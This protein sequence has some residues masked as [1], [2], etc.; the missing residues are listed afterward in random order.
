MAEDYDEF[1]DKTKLTQDVI[2]KF[3]SM[4]DK[5]VPEK[6]IKARL[7]LDEID[8][9][10]T[11]PEHMKGNEEDWEDDLSLH[12]IQTILPKMGT[13]AQATQTTG[14]VALSE[15]LDIF[16]KRLGR[17]KR[18]STET[19]LVGGGN[20]GVNTLKE[21]N[22]DPKMI[23][24]EK[25]H[26]YT[27][28]NK[29]YDIKAAKNQLNFL[30]KT[31]ALPKPILDNM[32][33]LLNFLK[34]KYASYKEGEEETRLRFEFIDMPTDSI[35]SNKKLLDINQRKATYE[36]WGEVYDKFE[37]NPKLIGLVK[38]FSVDNSK[39]PTKQTQKIPSALNIALGGLMQAIL[40]KNKT[41]AEFKESIKKVKSEKA[42][43]L[44]DLFNFLE[45]VEK[46][47]SLNYIVKVGHKDVKIKDVEE[48]AMLFIE[49]FLS[50]HDRLSSI[51][52]VDDVEMVYDKVTT[53]EGQK[54]F[55]E[56]EVKDKETF[57]EQDNVLVED[58]EQATLDP[59][60]IKY[61]KDDL[62]ELAEF[63]SDFNNSML[64][65]LRE[66]FE[67]Y[68]VYMADREDYEDMKEKL[69]EALESIEVV[70]EEKF[71]LPIFLFNTPALKTYFPE[72][73]GIANK[74]QEDILK[75]LD[76]YSNLLEDE[77]TFSAQNIQDIY[78][79]GTGKR[80]L[81]AYEKYKKYSPS[82]QGT[83]RK[84]RGK[85]KKAI[86]AINDYIVEL[87]VKPMHSIHRFGMKLPFEKG[88]QL[89]VIAS[90]VDDAGE[91]YL[92]YKEISK[93][94]N[95]FDTAF[96]D[97]DAVDATMDFIRI[98]TG[99][100]IYNKPEKTYG[101]SE[102]FV[103]K[104]MKVFNKNQK[105]KEQL[106]KEVASLYGSL[107]YVSNKTETL[108]DFMGE[109]VKEAFVKNRVDDPE[110]IQVLQV[111]TNAL[112]EKK[113]TVIE[114]SGGSIKETT[115]D[116]LMSELDRVAK[117]EIYSKLL[118]A[119]DSL[120]ILKGKEIHYAK[121]NENNFDHVEDMLIKMQ[122]EHN[123]DMSAGEL[124]SIVNEIDSFDNI[125]KAHGINSEHVYLIKANFR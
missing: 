26:L 78:V 111:L 108:A 25:L 65:E 113:Q 79:A 44:E 95:K 112:R 116:T 19:K 72:E 107:L 11:T 83:V 27:K 33:E 67:E 92:A 94:M 106:I 54:T 13:K 80:E 68:E 1:I 109:D 6:R 49:K 102:R 5:G 46:I 34:Q 15:Q 2:D 36:Y 52:D 61:L 39:R 40:G 98:V 48:R 42:L 117:S 64:K 60:A 115:Y 103:K 55:A 20:L 122:Q 7:D 97:G 17:T 56:M 74:I 114:G 53:E 84:F 69:E 51:F 85:L 41:T 12:I 29:N 14:K 71:H 8:G 82:K 50:H 16:L 120:R 100:D 35:F 4:V 88:I 59:L 28:G 21:R 45:V 104:I 38:D 10:I 18:Y 96:I 86:D 73:A 118:E 110:E 63:Y 76:A 24:V 77:K 3:Q 30:K 121:R 37:K 125:S 58:L 81:D 101:T 22:F 90:S 66:Q 119:H 91:G 124:V 123:L 89:R 62:G 99:A 93:R 75:F 32:A 23:D 31:K 70:D 9:L 57:D 47:G 43:E 105:I 87:F